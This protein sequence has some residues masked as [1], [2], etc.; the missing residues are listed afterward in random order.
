MAVKSGPD[1]VWKAIVEKY[2][3]SHRFGRVDW[4]RLVCD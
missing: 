4:K 1:K 3:L 2:N